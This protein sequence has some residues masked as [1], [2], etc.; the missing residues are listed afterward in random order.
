MVKLVREDFNDRGLERVKRVI[1]D[2]FYRDYDREADESDFRNPRKVSLAYT[3]TYDDEKEV[4]V[5]ADITSGKLYIRRGDETYVEDYGSPDGLADALE[6]VTFD[7]IISIYA[8]D[9]S[10]FYDLLNSKAYS[11]IKRNVW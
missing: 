1:S 4:Q 3:T 2:Y 5:Y 7:D 9:D 6:D 10:D 11:Y 8:N